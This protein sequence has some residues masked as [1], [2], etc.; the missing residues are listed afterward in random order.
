M[1]RFRKVTKCKIRNVNV[2]SKSSCAYRKCSAFRL[3][4][5]YTVRVVN[6]VPN[7]VCIV[8]NSK[9]TVTNSCCTVPNSKVQFPI[10]IYS[11]E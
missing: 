11:S 8:P 6:V 1:Y 10:A 4:N 5:A 2:V 9:C 7:S 3:A